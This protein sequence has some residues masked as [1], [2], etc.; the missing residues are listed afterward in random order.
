MRTQEEIE[1]KLEECIMK[2]DYWWNKI[3]NLKELEYP[4]QLDQY[5]DSREAWNQRVLTLQYVLGICEVI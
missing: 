2:R 3:R 4:E 1:K 5:E